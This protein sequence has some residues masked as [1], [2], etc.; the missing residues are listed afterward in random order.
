[1][2]PQLRVVPP[3]QLPSNLRLLLHLNHRVRLPARRVHRCTHL[4]G[5]AAQGS[6]Q[7]PWPWVPARC[8]TRC[9][10]LLSGWRT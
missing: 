1:M 10:R 6:W 9:K 7:M 3:V 8:F 5:L 4:L 2:L